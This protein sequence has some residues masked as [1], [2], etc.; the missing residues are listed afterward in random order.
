ME[1]W[2]KDFWEM[3]Q[4]LADETERFFIGMTEW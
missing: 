4:T 3:V 1:N 2:Q